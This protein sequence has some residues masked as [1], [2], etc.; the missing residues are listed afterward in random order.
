MQYTVGQSY[1][2]QMEVDVPSGTHR[3]E[4][5]YVPP[6][7]MAGAY[8][9]FPAWIALFIMAGQAW[10]RRRLPVWVVKIPSR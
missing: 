3:V 10:R 5:N 4:F 2:F 1:H 7:I 9:G 8:L 6:G